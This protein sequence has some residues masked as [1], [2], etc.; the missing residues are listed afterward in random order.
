[1]SSV[2]AERCC[3]FASTTASLGSAAQW[4]LGIG[5]MLMTVRGVK[6]LS[7]AMVCLSRVSTSIYN[8][9]IGSLKWVVATSGQKA[10]SLGSMP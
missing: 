3:I 4:G 10:S 8:L 9:M 7:G 5:R 1:M 6:A 2:A